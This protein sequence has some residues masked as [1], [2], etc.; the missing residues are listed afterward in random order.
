MRGCARE[1]TNQNMSY[2]EFVTDCFHELSTKQEKL[3]EQYDL[4]SYPNWFYDQ[5]SGILT[6]SG[7]GR[8]L[9]FRF[10]EVGTYARVPKTWKWSWDN[11][12]TLAKVKQGLEVIKQYGDEHRFEK[13]TQ[14]LF[15]STEDEGWDFTSIATKLLNGIGA[16]RPATEKHLIFMVLY[17]VVD[18]ETAREEKEKYID[19]EYHE[20]RR[21]A[22]VCQH[23]KNG[24]KKG[25]EEAF[26]TYEDMEFEY[27]DDNFQAWCDECEIVRL[28]HEG[29]N[30]ESMKFAKIRL[31]CEECYFEIKAMNKL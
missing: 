30:D 13:L 27:E 16:Y 29:W 20:R 7:E 9:N 23:L 18:E 28:A 31:V 2:S 26:E 4:D 8:E 14:G 17:E 22:F 6:F 3:T 10:Y 12:H 19:C 5:A 15:D 11:E 24:S 25:F 1:I 21:I